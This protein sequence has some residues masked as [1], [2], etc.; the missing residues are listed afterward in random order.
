MF[1]TFQNATEMDTPQTKH[2]SG[3]L[4]R[5]GG[6]QSACELDLLVFLYRHPRNLLTS[7]QLAE[8]VGYPLKDLAKALERFI[9]AGFLERTLQ[10]SGHAARMFRLLLEGP[11]GNGVS[12]L[13]EMASTRPGRQRIL[14]TI[15]ND[16]RSRAQTLAWSPAWIIMK[17]GQS[18]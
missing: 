13:V 5:A 4:L 7:E 8:F 16:G 11:S 14:K 6:I 10:Q 12:T 18:A 15:Q 2:I 1:L 3:L 17:G 9:E